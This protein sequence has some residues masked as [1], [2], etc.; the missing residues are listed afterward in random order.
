MSHRAIAGVALAVLAVAAAP[1]TAPAQTFVPP[2]PGANDRNDERDDGPD[3]M[4]GVSLICAAD[5]VGSGAAA[6]VG[7]AVGAGAD[8]AA[9][10]VMGGVVGWAASGAAWLVSAIVR[11]VDRSTR[12]QLGSPWFERRYAAMREIG[13]SLSLVFL[14]AALIHAVVRQD[15][16]ML[17]R[18][19]LVALPL[20]L[21]LTFAATTLAELGLALTDGLTAGALGR[22]GKDAREAFGDFSGIFA[23]AAPGT[24]ALPGL[25]LLLGALLTAV[26]ALVVWIE[27]ILREAAIYFSV[28]FLPIALAG[29]V[30]PRTAHWSKR[31]A[32]WLAA[33]ILAKFAI[34]TA[35]ALA[36]SMLGHARSGT[37]GLS[38]LLAGCAVLLL[39]A[40]SPWV[41]L[42][43]IPFVEQAAG[44]LHR[45]Q[46]R[47]ALRTA[48]GAAATPLLVHQAMLKNFAQA[49]PATSHPAL[50]ARQW[51]PRR[52]VPGNERATRLPLG[53]S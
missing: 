23:P 37:G 39:A 42:R 32:E 29:A 44:G 10:A 7:G 13:I 2:I 22:S 8:A 33:I 51:T 49:R 9:D 6:L 18:S 30:W 48:P 52:S 4:P 41:L 5:T 31:L 26:L 27:L 28:A 12:P 24:D 11:Q 21:L 35:F 3:C 14:I 47:G 46:V 36:G 1:P 17:A 38:A 45:G 50:R 25:V 19:A 15:M 43:L 16:A 20:S 53:P 34:A 40:L